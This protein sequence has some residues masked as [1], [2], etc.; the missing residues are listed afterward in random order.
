MLFYYL[1]QHVSTYT[2]DT[3][4]YVESEE[5]LGTACKLSFGAHHSQYCPFARIKYKQVDYSASNN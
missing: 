2:V 5:R 3:V 1:G 4:R